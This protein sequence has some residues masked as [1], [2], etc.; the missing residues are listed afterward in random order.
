MPSAKW[1][2]TQ[3]KRKKLRGYCDTAEN[4]GFIIKYLKGRNLCSCFTNAYEMLRQFNFAPWINTY[5]TNQNKLKRVDTI[6]YHVRKHQIL[7]HKGGFLT[8][9]WLPFAML[10]MYSVT[11]SRTLFWDAE[12]LKN[13]INWIH[14]FHFCPAAMDKKTSNPDHDLSGRVS[15]NQTVCFTNEALCVCM[16]LS[17]RRA[18]PVCPV[19]GIW[20]IVTFLRK[21]KETFCKVQTPFAWW[22]IIV[23]AIIMF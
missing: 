8:L 20:N 5:S 22:K 13:T 6:L 14:T 3:T 15:N 16:L 11:V 4:I 12:K 23:T 17:Y 21:E 19:Q 10:K 7:A 18:G 9:Q 1:P 2:A